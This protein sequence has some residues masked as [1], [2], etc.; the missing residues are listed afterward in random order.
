M[1]H[2]I[3]KLG[4]TFLTASLL[5][6]TAAAGGDSTEDPDKDYDRLDGSGK[7]QKTVQVIEWDGNLEIHVFPKGSLKSLAAKL[8]DTNKNKKVMIL[9]YRFKD[10]P[11]MQYVRRNILGISITQNF[12]TYLN[13]SDPDYDNYIFSNNGLSNQV[14]AYNLEPGPQNS[15]PEGDPRNKAKE[16]EKAAAPVE[17]PKFDSLANAGKPNSANPNSVKKDSR[18]PAAAT[19]ASVAQSS[20]PGMTATTPPAAAAPEKDEWEMKP[21]KKA[22]EALII[23]PTEESNEGKSA[24]GWSF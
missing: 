1:N 2:F 12:K 4:I 7:S 21:R 16:T 11:Q 19:P 9:G 20:A 8:D 6:L 17:T 10:E 22:R 5:A 15:Y 23:R 13:S 18:S 3:K 24:S 14:V